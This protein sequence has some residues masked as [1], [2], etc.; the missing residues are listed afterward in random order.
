MVDSC[1]TA[2][3]AVETS[4][5]NWSRKPTSCPGLNCQNWSVQFQTRA[6]TRPADSWLE[7]SGPISGSAF[8]VPHLSSNSDML[9]LI[10]KDWHSYVMVYFRL[11]S[12]LDVRNSDT[13]APNHILK[14]SANRASTV[15]Q[16]SVNRASTERHQS[17]N[18][19]STI[20]GL[21]SS[22]I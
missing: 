22:A 21:A 14:M 5:S 2:Q 20:L 10:I 11:I 15:R 13:H 12:R 16:Q 19:A 18:R 4:V 8:R 7:P 17:V 3:C 1:T 9:L 6:T